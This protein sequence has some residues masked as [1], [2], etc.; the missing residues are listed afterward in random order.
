MARFLA[1]RS[2]PLPSVQEQLDWEQKR[3]RYKGSNNLFHEIKPD[4][5][6]YF[7]WLKEFAGPAAE[8]SD[9]YELPDWQDVWAAQGFKVLQLKDK[10]WG[11][12]RG[13]PPALAPKPKL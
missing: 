10:Y 12:V 5:G 13:A 9:A 8:G 4:F 7:Q 11:K 3:I 2:Q 6:E 1:G